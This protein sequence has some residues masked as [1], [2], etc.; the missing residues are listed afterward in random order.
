MNTNPVRDGR[1]SGG[2]RVGAVALLLAVLWMVFVFLYLSSH[3]V[4]PLRT[5]DELAA[6]AN[7]SAAGFRPRCLDVLAQRPEASAGLIALITCVAMIVVAVV[8]LLRER[9]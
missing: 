2:F 3:S 4:S 5:C 1:G 9:R 7:A 8:L 6:I